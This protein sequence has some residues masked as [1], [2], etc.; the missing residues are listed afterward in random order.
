LTSSSLFFLSFS[1]KIMFSRLALAL[2]ATATF[3]TVASAQLQILS[4]GGSNEWWIANSTNLLTWNCN[5]NTDPNQQ[6][7]TV[8]VNNPTN[9]D[10][11]SAF[12]IISIEENFV[13]DLLVTA[14]QMGAL[15]A[16]TG[17]VVQFANP[18]NNTDVY[19]QSAS[20]EIKPFG[21]TYPSTT[22]SESSSP[23]SSGSSSSASPTSGKSTTSN[24][25]AIL[26]ASMGY[27]TAFAVAVVGIYLL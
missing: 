25:G 18:L 1:S 2:A 19:V 12:A 4:P 23:T 17:Y 15:P 3:F 9:P 6:N 11:P 13:C 26:K 14:S 24:D 5:Q 7:F 10:L 8:L 16:G 21:S 22:A 20:F 27:A